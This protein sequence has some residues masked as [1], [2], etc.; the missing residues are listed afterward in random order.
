MKNNMMSL[1]ALSVAVVILA[2]GCKTQETIHQTPGEYTREST[3]YN[4]WISR[5]SNES[6]SS[7]YLSHPV[8]LGNPQ[9]QATG[10]PTETLQETSDEGTLPDMS[11]FC[12][13]NDMPI[14]KVYNTVRKVPQPALMAW[15]QGASIAMPPQQSIIVHSGTWAGGYGDGGYA[16]IGSGLRPW[17]QPSIPDRSRRPSSCFVQQAPHPHS[18]FGGNGNNGWNGNHGGQQGG[19]HH[20]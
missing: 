12:T 11:M 17:Y 8:L 1:W 9:G 14:A 5:T 6:D 20:H 13:A 15:E 18:M 19:S 16:N 10:A 3:S 7:R 4:S 2:T